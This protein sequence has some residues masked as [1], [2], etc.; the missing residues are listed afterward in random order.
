MAQDMLD[1]VRVPGLVLPDGIDAQI[2]LHVLGQ[3][4]KG[5]L[6]E[7]M[8]GRHAQSTLP[9]LPAWV[10]ATLGNQQQSLCTSVKSHPSLFEFQ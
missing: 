2:H 7:I 5:L 10:W 8:E 6:V 9:Q 1:V 3:G 4:L